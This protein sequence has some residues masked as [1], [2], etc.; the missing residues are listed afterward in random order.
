MA[1]IVFAIVGACWS[2][3]DKRKE[4]KQRKQLEANELELKVQDKNGQPTPKQKASISP[5]E[6]TF[7]QTAVGN[8]Q[9]D[10][11]NEAGTQE[12]TC[13]GKQS[14]RGELG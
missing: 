6:R 1:S 8:T 4:E 13:A 2:C 12:N 10:P 5:I 9:A 7:S 11:Q 3:A 14:D